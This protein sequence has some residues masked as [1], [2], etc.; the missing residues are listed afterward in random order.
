MI[1][2]FIK[3]RWFLTKSRFFSTLGLA[4]LLPIFLHVSINFS[5]KYVNSS[6]AVA[7]PYESWSLS[8]LLML[9]V[10]ISLIPIVYRDLFD[11]R[12]HKN[13]LFPLT[14]TPI[15][16]QKIILG[17]L[18]AAV[19]ESIIFVIIALIA[20]GLLTS[21][22]LSL[23]NYLVIIP[24]VI[25]YGFVIG[26]LFIS[27]SLMTN[28]IMNFLLL[29]ISTVLFI[30]FSSD[31]VVSINNFPSI[32]ENIFKYFPTTMLISGLRKILFDGNF[33]FISFLYPVIVGFVW[34]ILNGLLLKKKLNQ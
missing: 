29:I 7:I 10:T 17:F 25:A 3:R 2:S 19:L 21:N 14:I 8:G 34:T 5:M 16:K 11:L 27:F 20:L 31:S 30:T 33:N 12:I 23:I 4:L 22:L 1:L 26:N 32:L 6:N 15:S 28:R 24:Y 13:V 9:V 18:F